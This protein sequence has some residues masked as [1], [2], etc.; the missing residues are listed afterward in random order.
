MDFFNTTTTD[1]SDHGWMNL[2][3]IRSSSINNSGCRKKLVDDDDDE[4]ELSALC[5]SEKVA[6]LAIHFPDRHFPARCTIEPK[7]SSSNDNDSTHLLEDPVSLCFVGGIVAKIRTFCREHKAVDTNRCSCRYL[8]T[9]IIS[10]VPMFILAT[11]LARDPFK[12]TQGLHIFVW[13]G[14]SVLSGKI[15]DRAFGQTAEYLASKQKFKKAWKDSNLLFDLARLA[16]QCGYGLEEVE[17]SS[18]TDQQ[19]MLVVY[20]KEDCV[21]SLPEVVDKD[22]VDATASESD[23][24]EE[25]NSQ[26]ILKIWEKYKFIQYAPRDSS[27]SPPPVPR[28]NPDDD[29]EPLEEVSFPIDFWIVNG[30]VLGIQLDRRA[31][32]KFLNVF[33]HI[34]SILVL[35]SLLGSLN[36]MVELKFAFFMLLVVPLVLIIEL[37]VL[38]QFYQWFEQ[39]RAL[40]AYCDLASNLSPLIRDRHGGC[41]LRHEV[42]SRSDSVWCNLICWGGRATFVFEHPVPDEEATVGIC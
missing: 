4:E 6:V 5:H 34:V 36:Y 11:L 16:N 26:A 29:A 28:A 38:I 2:F 21:Q 1:P 20:K 35:I 13:F 33:F 14:W 19:L 12:F 31:N 3:G 7:K 25:K 39:P 23:R 42:V 8:T 37:I 10:Y 15:V 27:P 22:N 30:I 40:Q 41:S 17:L 18:K 24:N 9:F 32:S